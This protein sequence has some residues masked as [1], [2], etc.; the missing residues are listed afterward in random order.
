[1]K[2][3]LYCPAAYL[4][5]L[6]ILIL[7]LLCACLIPN[8][9]LTENARTS[10]EYISEY[11]DSF[12][13]IERGGILPYQRQ[14]NYA[15]MIL[16][17]IAISLDTSKPLESMLEA[18]YL[19]DPYRKSSDL[20]LAR[21][22][23]EGVNADYSRY[24]HGM[25]IFIRPLLTVTTYPVMRVIN[26]VV[27]GGLFAWLCILLMRRGLWQL[28]LATV[29]A[30]S[31][32]DFA[33]AA[34]C[35]EFYIMCMISLLA[36]CLALII[37]KRHTKTGRFID[38][39]IHLLVFFTF[40]GTATCFFDFLTAETL[41]ILLPLIM[42]LVTRAVGSDNKADD[43]RK[44]GIT[45]KRA[46]ML[47]VSSAAVWGIAYALTYVMKWVLAAAVSPDIGFSDAFGYAGVRAVGTVENAV[48]P[49]P[50]ESFLRNL[51]MLPILCLPKTDLAIWAVIGIFGAAVL[52]YLAACGRPIKEMGVPAVIWLL[53]LVPYVRYI[54]LCNHSTLH[55][56]FTYRAQAS[57][58]IATIAA[59]W[60]ACEPTLY[61]AN[62][63]H[64]WKRRRR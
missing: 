50:Y 17:N 8:S 39:E 5:G 22:D 33:S 19:L 49:L 20:V 58:I 48:F 31:V 11:E 32:T 6:T 7:L 27:L 41:T 46:F 57:S 40:V 14:D 26:S 35:F 34:L 61:G 18:N 12:F 64:A 55:H 45:T 13:D 30:C 3:L 63:K 53:A 51:A 37:D 54:V 52:V 28:A 38:D 29:F 59:L 4:A 36:S 10:A 56:F 1:M 15:D 2:K 43:Q 47:I 60:L 25:L 42:V 62:S 44:F 16:F 21:L 9:A 24:W 23:G